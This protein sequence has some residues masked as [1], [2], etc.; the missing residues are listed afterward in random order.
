M[1]RIMRIAPIWGCARRSYN[2]SQ[3]WFFGGL[4]LV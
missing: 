1:P 4:D 2:D 3:K